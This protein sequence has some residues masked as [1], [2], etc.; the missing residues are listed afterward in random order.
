MEKNVLDKRNSV[1]SDS[2]GGKKKTI[3]SMDLEC[4]VVDVREREMHAKRSSNISLIISE[5][6]REE[7]A[8]CQ[9]YVSMSMHYRVDIEDMK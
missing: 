4:A 7:V 6:T 9:C 5:F 1:T 8:I 2:C 3:I